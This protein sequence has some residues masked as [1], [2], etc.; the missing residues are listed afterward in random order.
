MEDCHMGSN[1][2]EERYKIQAIC[3]ILVVLLLLGTLIRNERHL[4]LLE[5]ELNDV[6]GMEL[7]TLTGFPGPSRNCNHNIQLRG[8]PPGRLVR[9]SRRTFKL[10]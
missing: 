2:F 10:S 7:T 9:H 5:K 6:G 1:K 4:M 8:L 3:H